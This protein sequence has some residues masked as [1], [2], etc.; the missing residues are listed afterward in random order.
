MQE[1]ILSSILKLP[2]ELKVSFL[3][4]NDNSGVFL[5]HEL[6]DKAPRIVKKMAYEVP[7]LLQLL[8]QKS[9]VI[10]QTD[11]A[12]VF[13]QDEYTLCQILNWTSYDKRIVLYSFESLKKLDTDVLQHF[14]TSQADNL[15]F[16]LQD[17][18]G[19]IPQER[20][21]K[22]RV[23]PRYQVHKFNITVSSADRPRISVI[24][25]SL[26]GL[27]VRSKE[28]FTTGTSE[29]WQVHYLKYSIP[30]ISSAL[31]NEYESKNESFF[32]GCRIQLLNQED[33]D[34]WLKFVKA[35]HLY[36]SK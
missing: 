8:C 34:Q 3:F 20:F 28:N 21:V 30:V 4:C 11:G 12:S 35:M 27:K 31:W 18:Y 7:A 15:V 33:F 23:F 16:Y 26:S 22:C 13:I 17:L 25:V 19:P 36:N 5:Y 14:I 10:E 9:G 1:Q 29:K 2:F 32:I 6:A 24:D